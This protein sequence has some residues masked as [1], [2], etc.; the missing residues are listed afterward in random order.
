MTT[1]GRS[2]GGAPPYGSY[3]SW[4][5][6][7]A[8]LKTDLL[9]LPGRLDSSVWRNTPFS[10]STRSAVKSALFFFGLID[11]SGK[12]EPR[13]TLLAEA[14]NPEA[15]R[16]VLGALVEERY[17]PIL[18]SV[19]LLRA[20]R[21]EIKTAFQN[22]GSGTETSEKAV[23][24]FVSFARDAGKELHPNLFSRVQG[25]RTRRKT[26]ANRKDLV[27]RTG[28][29]DTETKIEIITEK[30]SM[31]SENGIVRHDEVHPALLGVLEILP[32][33][34]QTWTDSAR[35]KA[36][37]AFNNILDLAYPTIDDTNQRML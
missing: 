27:D 2:R 6:F 24:F 11:P 28:K 3:K 23:S 37:I 17:G 4:E 25:T 35:E 21:G 33:G 15:K 13:L 20:T 32:K 30:T 26:A 5:T 34:G 19:D 10:G 8:Y 14:D 9:P 7:V 12:T 29:T 22:A 16:R 36:K 1:G 31:P 18:D